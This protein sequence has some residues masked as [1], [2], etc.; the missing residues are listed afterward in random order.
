MS[1]T[2]PPV[3]RAAGVLLYCTSLYD[4]SIPDATTLTNNDAAAKRFLLMRHSNRWDLPKGHCDGDESFRETAIREMEEET[5]IAAHRV[6]LDPTFRFDLR[7]PVTYRRH[8]DQVFDKH[9]RY[10]LGQL[11]A[12][13]LQTG[14]PEIKV[15]EHDSYQ[16]FDWNPPH[17]IQT[18]TIDPL[19]FAVAKHWNG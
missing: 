5:G 8:G 10:F 15:T 18:E 13:D 1:Q 9:V 3:V 4:T 14:P 16:W 6:T 17:R 7:Y 19:L 12:V 11:D 2:P